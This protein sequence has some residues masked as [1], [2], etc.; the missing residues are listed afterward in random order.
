[1]LGFDV[2]IA[3]GP[4][5]LVGSNGNQ[6]T[7]ATAGHYDVGTTFSNI[8]SFDVYTGGVP[9]AAGGVNTLSGHDGFWIDN[10]LWLG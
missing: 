4:T 9:G 3:N 1:V 2:P 7:I 8:T 5:V 6:M 10:L